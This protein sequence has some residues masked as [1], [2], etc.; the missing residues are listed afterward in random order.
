MAMGRLHED[1][2]THSWGFDVP[3]GVCAPIHDELIL[4]VPIKIVQEVATI[5]KKT[6]IDVAEQMCPGIK[7]NADV[8]IGG[9]WSEKH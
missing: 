8:A 9:R 4:D 6:M 7:F 3:F 1:W 2:Y 5:L